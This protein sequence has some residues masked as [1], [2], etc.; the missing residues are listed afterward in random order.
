MI[1]FSIVFCLILLALQSCR[2]TTYT[3]K[4]RGYAMIEFPKHEYQPFHDQ[5]FPYSFEYPTYGRIVKDTLFFGQKPENPYWIN[6]DFPEIGGIIYISYKPI[7]AQQPLGKLLE[8]SHEMS[9]TAH[10]KRADYINEDGVFSN[11]ERN[12]YGILYNV[13]GNAASAYQFIATDS[14][15]HFIRGA[16]YFDVS[17]NAD[18][19]KPSNEFLRKDIEHLLETLK[20]Q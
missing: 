17:P 20:W 18:S 16:L 2:P 11:R 8:D 3:P 13:G 5:D 9:F 14:V 15:K 10:S 4:P 19:L 1:R 6:I 12:V 7:S